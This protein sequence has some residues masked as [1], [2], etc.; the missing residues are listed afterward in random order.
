MF[1]S[2]S[3]CCLAAAPLGGAVGDLTSGFMTS[4]SP[5]DEVS[6]LL[7]IAFSLLLY[8]L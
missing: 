3:C 6:V 8:M 7:I 4:L 2:W 1:I 5:F